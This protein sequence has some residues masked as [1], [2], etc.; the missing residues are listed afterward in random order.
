[1]EMLAIAV[2]MIIS[3]A[4]DGV[5]TFTDRLFLARISSEQ[6]NAAMGGGI[7]VQVLLFFFIGL[8]GYSTALVAQYLGAG[9]KQ[10]SSMAAFQA[11]L[12][13]LIASPF[14]YIFAQFAPLFFALMQVPSEQVGFQIIYF[15]ILVYGAPISLL[16]SSMSCYFSGIGKT[17][18]VMYANLLAMVI[19]VVLDYILIFGKLGFEP[20]GVKGAAIATVIGGAC[21][22]LLMF[23]SYISHT[24]RVEF[25][26]M[27]SFRF[28]KTIMKKL[29]YFG[30]PA[31]LEFFL[32][33]LAF[34]VIIFLF[35]SKGSHVAT[36]STIMFNWDLVSFIPLIGIEIAVTSLA[37]RYMGAGE[38]DI[39]NRVAA[40]GIKIGIFYSF[41]ILI[42]FVFFTESL[43]NVFHPEIASASFEQ[44]RPI[45]VAMIQL[46]SLYVLAEAL[47]V[48]FVGVLRGAGDTHWTMRASVAFHWIL[49]PALYIIMNVFNLSPVT[50]WLFLVLLFLTFCIFLYLRYR[51]GKWKL[52][53]VV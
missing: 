14:I 1:M 8:I 22:L 13:A 31:G 51:S 50:G 4:C 36:A 16:R 33:F 49:A 2:P 32:N 10:Y 15:D 21:G 5:M 45:A 30:Y 9:Q 48:A 46:A 12:V 26:V 39:V 41:V 19:N 23:S 35:H 44:A 52:I 27:K 7:L 47:M 34:S 17:K 6:M 53:K 28:N 11:M 24:N 38:P 43:V 37:G 18:I 25:S 42:L 20:M 3:T 40:S 29:I